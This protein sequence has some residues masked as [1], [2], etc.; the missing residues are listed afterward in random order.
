MKAPIN[1]KQ[2]EPINITHRYKHNSNSQDCCILSWIS[3]T[4]TRQSLRLDTKSNMLF[5]VHIFEMS[6][7]KVFF[8]QSIPAVFLWIR[9]EMK[10]NIE[11][12]IKVQT[13]LLCFQKQVMLNERYICLWWPWWVNMAQFYFL[14]SKQLRTE[15]RKSEF[16][17]GIFSSAF[18]IKRES[19]RWKKSDMLMTHIISHVVRQSL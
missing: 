15:D 2:V 18:I 6:F 4:I 7:L 14:W 5:T 16:A 8:F 19:L 3:F 12:K 9:S 13:T 10:K 1:G 11:A 17:S